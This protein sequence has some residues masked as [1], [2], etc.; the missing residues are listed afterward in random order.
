M[1][2]L[3]AYAPARKPAVLVPACN[4]MVGQHPFHIA[5][6]KY[7]DAIRLAGCLPLIVPFVQ[8]DELDELLDHADGVL[9]TGS[10]SNVHPS[11]FGEDVYDPTLPLDQDRDAWTLPMIPRALARGI[12]LFAICRGFQE[13]NVALGGSLY[14][15]VQEVPGQRDHRGITD[16]TPEEQYDF[17]HEV[18]VEAGGAL[19]TI[20]GT[21]EFKVNTAH[22]QGVKQLAPGLRVEARAPDGLVEAFSMNNAPGF[23][24]CVQW[25]PEW[26]AASNPISLQLF[27]AFGDACRAYRDRHR[28]PDPDR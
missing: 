17:A 8:A 12:P 10:P 7:I 4:R 19:E 9:L 21:R 26:K 6:K 28:Q 25:H 14:Q 23:N 15:A 2:A 3:P 1:S 11:H 13:A 20:V 18:L 5:G 22:G 27:T 24:L 16:K